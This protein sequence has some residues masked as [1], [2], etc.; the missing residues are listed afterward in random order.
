MN[1]RE[2][3][4]EDLLIEIDCLKQKAMKSEKINAS[5]VETATDAIITIDALGTILSWNNAAQ[6]IFGY[7][8]SEIISKSIFKIISKKSTC[9]L[10]GD[11]FEGFLKSEIKINSGKTIEIIGKKKSDEEFQTE[12]SI[13]KWELNGHSYYTGVFRD[14]TEHKKKDSFLR[15]LNLAIKNSMDIVF[16]TDAN[17]TITYVNPQ[18]TKTYG[19][20]PHE[21]LGKHTPRILKSEDNKERFELLWKTILGKNSFKMSHYRNKKKDGSLI[22]IESTIDPILDDNDNIIGFLGIQ[23]DI[24]ERINYIAELEDAIEKAKEADRLKSEFLATMSHELRTPLN[25][26]IGLSSL[27][28]DNSPMY[29]ILEY[30]KIINNSGEHLLKLIEDLF[31]I[32]LVESGKSKPF[33]KEINLTIF[34]DEIHELMKVHQEKL[35]KNHISF[36]LN[37]PSNFKNLTIVTDELKLKHILINL[38]KNAF[39]FS[40]NGTINYGFEVTEIEGENRIKF[41]VSDTGIG[42]DKNHQDLIFRGFTQVNSSYNRKYEGIGIG[43]TI[44]KKLVNLLKG[45][46]WLDSRVGKGSTFFFSFPL[47][48]IYCEAGKDS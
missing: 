29:E 6:T 13:S 2:K 15:K 31:D 20:E 45:E 25:S 37:I 19:Y 24:T 35:D 34:M 38:I 32:S 3:S 23:H 10:R 9:E 4:M 48:D 14:I 33:M 41:F 12:L 40:E 42:I 26:I 5:I 1:T 22:D 43:L 11:D 47:N 36:N 8:S 30:N 21:V 28:D 27:I 46:I 44:T 39:K 17:G 18:F 7:K 16:M